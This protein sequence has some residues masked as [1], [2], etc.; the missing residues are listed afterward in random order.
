MIFP[1][2]A[3]QSLSPCP[4]NPVADCRL[5]DAEA[6]GDFVLGQAAADGLD[7]LTT[8]LSRQALLLMAISRRNTVF[9]KA[10]SWRCSFNRSRAAVVQMSVIGRLWQPPDR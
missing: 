3:L 6:A 9:I 7:D 1:V 2:D 10:T 4:L 8:A 5:R